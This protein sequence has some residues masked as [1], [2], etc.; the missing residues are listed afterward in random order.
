VYN[1]IAQCLL[2]P[3]I[4]KTSN[5]FTC[6]SVCAYRLLTIL[7]FYFFR[8]STILFDKS[9]KN[10]PR[11]RWSRKRNPCADCCKV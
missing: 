9:T 8:S 10:L 11:K 3:A 7:I 1:L 4:I 5:I 6:S 2:T